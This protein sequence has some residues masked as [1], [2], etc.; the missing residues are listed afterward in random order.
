M[1]LR[2][3]SW[4]E[5]VKLRDDPQFPLNFHLPPFSPYGSLTPWFPSPSVHKLFGACG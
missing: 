1:F 5:A 4:G 2:G 3:F